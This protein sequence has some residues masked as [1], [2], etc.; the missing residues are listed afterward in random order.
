MSTQ[1]TLKMKDP[2]P[3]GIH[4]IDL[5]MFQEQSSHGVV[6]AKHSV[7]KGGGHENKEQT[8]QQQQ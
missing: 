5:M 8:K 2:S 4:K 3:E 6:T 1:K 7:Y